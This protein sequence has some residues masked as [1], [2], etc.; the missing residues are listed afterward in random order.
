MD[1]IVDKEREQDMSEFAHKKQVKDPSTSVKTSASG[2]QRHR[3]KQP[4]HH[5]LHSQL[6]LG[7]QNV[8]SKHADSTVNEKKADAIS[9][10]SG[11]PLPG[12]LRTSME[13]YF[14]TSLSHVRIHADAQS[15]ASAERLNARAYT[16]GSNIHLGKESVG[17]SGKAHSAL[18]AHEVVHTMQQGPVQARAKPKVGNSDDAFEQQADTLAAGYSRYVRNPRD[19]LAI[20]L[21]NS[22]PVRKLSGGG[23]VIQRSR[24][25]THFGEFEDYKYQDMTDSSGSQVGVEMYMKFHPGNN[26][27]AD[28]I[29]MTQAAEGQLNSNQINQGIYGQRS[30]T[31]GA[32]VGHFI[33]RLEGYPNPIYPTTKSVVA[34]GSASDLADYQTTGITALTPA[35]QTAQAAST[36]ITGR[37]Y[38]GWGQ[39]GYRKVVSGSYVTQAA[40]LYDAPAVGGAGANSEQVFETTALAI[41][42]S[43][44]GTYYGSVEWGW[45]KD[46][47]GTF[48]RLPFRLVSQGVPSVN[49]LTAANIWNVSK[50]SFGYVTTAATNLL[51]GSLSPLSA[52]P[53]NTELTPTGRQGAAGGVT[54]IEVTH[55]GN[56][57]FVTS[58]AVRAT[59]IGAD[60]VDLPVPLIHTVSNPLGT[61][62]IYNP[63]ISL[64]TL[65]L[66]AG[67][68]IRTT[69]CMVPRG[70][71]TNH[72]EGEIV[73]GPHT[74]TH[75]YFYVPDIQR[76]ALGT[77]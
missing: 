7:E 2:K 11:K 49:F 74:G 41:S 55:G 5:E 64:L 73:D 15:Q 62:M 34:G 48:S 71:L 14:N 25:S 77:R 38:T 21:R 23:S 29:G 4:V 75:G 72:Y 60:T 63:A 45:R 66:P 40:E 18:L 27:R 3:E 47:T 32:G 1:G 42:G 39:H 54:Y 10:G 8:Q 12:G 52:I 33:D 17:A 51:D 50:A 19:Q 68:R 26:V 9:A 24:I 36:G 46:A 70:A 56:T 6:S 13:S 35:Q 65:S 37:R 67:T 43:D 31:R 28:L 69:R 20:G 57:G 58:T 59:T 30:A 76:E 22:T 44:R 16:L 53:A 61:R